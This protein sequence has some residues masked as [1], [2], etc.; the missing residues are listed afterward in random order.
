[1]RHL[2][3]PIRQVDHMTVRTRSEIL[4]E[5]FC[6]KA[7]IPFTCIPPESRVGHPTPDYE[8]RLQLPAILAEVKQIDPNHEDKMLLRE[9]QQTGAYEFEDILG[10]R[11]RGKI[12]EAASQLR[13]RLRPGQPALVIIYNNVDVLRGFTD[14]HHMMSAMYGLYEVV[15]TTSRGLAARLLS[16]SRRLGGSRRLTPEHNT[17]VS[18][19][20]VLFDGPE[21]PYLVVYH[22]RFAANPIPPELLRHAGILQRSVSD[23]GPAEF[24]EWVEL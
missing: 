1:V 4:F 7:G 8:L 23:R 9:L 21:G 19:V 15:F 14:P 20:A 6:D 22:N 11:L 17:T 24:P 13:A 18:A 12:S 3:I 16:I 5:R 10:K 2:P